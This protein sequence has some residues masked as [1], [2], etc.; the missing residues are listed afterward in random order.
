MN[1]TACSRLSLSLATALCR[2]GGKYFI[3][4]YNTGV[5]ADQYVANGTRFTQPLYTQEQAAETQRTRAE[6][7]DQDT[8]IIPAVTADHEA[9]LEWAADARERGNLV[10]CIGPE[11]AVQMRE[12]VDLYIT[13]GGHEDGGVVALPDGSR[14]CPVSGIL[15]NVLCQM[16]TA[17][18]CDEMCRRGA[19]P[20]W[21]Y[22]VNWVGGIEYNEVTRLA[23]EERG[24]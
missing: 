3:R 24:Y 9:E 19:I 8:F 18:V 4:G 20:I 23:F 6:G 13:N 21:L 15:N 2:R 5:Q 11:H 14:I 10:V 22:G 7:G 16:L 12:R 1:T 17:Q